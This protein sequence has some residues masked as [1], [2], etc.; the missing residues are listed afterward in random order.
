MISIEQGLYVRIEEMLGPRAP[1]PFPLQ[2]GFVLESAYRVL[3]IYNPSETSDAYLILSNER[4][5]IWFISNRHVRTLGFKSGTVL[6]LPTRD[7]T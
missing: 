3:G 5:E 7:F 2:S 4:D 1:T 6:R